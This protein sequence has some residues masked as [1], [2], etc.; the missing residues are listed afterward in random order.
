PQ[1]STGARSVVLDCALGGAERFGDLTVA[2][3]TVDQSKDFDLPFVDGPG[4]VAA[5]TSRRTCS[6]PRG[7]RSVTAGLISDLLRCVSPDQPVSTTLCT[8]IHNNRC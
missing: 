3:T 4:R 5:S 1:A 2:V 7:T 8:T 6:R